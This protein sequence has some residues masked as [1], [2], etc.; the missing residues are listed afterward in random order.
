MRPSKPS[1]RMAPRPC[2]T[3]VLLLLPSRNPF[4]RCANLLVR[5][6]LSH[7]STL[8]HS[9][10]PQC[11]ITHR[12]SEPLGCMAYDARTFTCQLMTEFFKWRN[13]P[14]ARPLISKDI[15]PD[16]TVVLLC[17]AVLTARHPGLHRLPSHALSRNSSW[18]PVAPT[19][20]THIHTCTITEFAQNLLHCAPCQS[21]YS[22]V[23]VC[24]S[25]TQSLSGK[26]LFLYHR[27]LFC[28]VVT[29]RG[30]LAVALA[31][32]QGTGDDDDDDELLIW[33]GVHFF[34]VGESWRRSLQ[35]WSRSCAPQ[36]EGNSALSCQPYQ[37]KHALP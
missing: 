28:R 9:L 33:S 34:L 19:V 29:S 21:S 13:L 26:R 2:T 16:V 31:H 30:V 17:C 14:I 6:S 5:A 35:N 3:L 11:H 25:A 18:Q 20:T 32:G 12:R 23:V 27:S 7:P 15:L 8:T 10:A 37:Q 22:V 1:T 24:F 36:P 4:M